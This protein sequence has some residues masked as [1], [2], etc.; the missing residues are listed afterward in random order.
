MALNKVVMLG[1][2]VRDPEVRYGNSMA[3]CL[4]T[5][6]VDRPKRTGEAE[7]DFIS[8]KAFGKTAEV[9]GNYFHKGSR[10]LISDGCIRVENYT[11]KTGA[12][13]SMTNVIVNSVEFIDKKA[14][15]KGDSSNF[16]SFGEEVDF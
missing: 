5:V 4:F 13:K 11:D 16:S 8:C 3:V 14:S 9:I 6:A 7:T 2:L 15:G 1:R 12:K 10:I